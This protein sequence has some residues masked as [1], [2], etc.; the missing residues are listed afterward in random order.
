MWYV[1][2]RPVKVPPSI[3]S[4][5]VDLLD[6]AAR[7]MIKGIGFLYIALQFLITDSMPVPKAVD[8]LI[9]TIPVV[10]LASYFALKLLP[11]KSALVI[12]QTG[13]S[14]AIV[15]IVRGFH[16]PAFGFLLIFLPFLC[17]ISASWRTNFV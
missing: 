9:F 5:A 10:V 8:F 14:V 16:Q 15:M 6:S 11:R 7:R 3:N 13:Y 2:G 12:W 4:E 17:V 1:H